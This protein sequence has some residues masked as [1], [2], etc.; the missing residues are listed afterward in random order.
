MSEKTWFDVHWGQRCISSP[1]STQIVRYT[2]PPIQW[3][4]GALKPDIKWLG[5]ETDYLPCL[6][7]GLRLT[8]LMAYTQTTVSLLF[9]FLFYTHMNYFVACCIT[10][11][12]QTTQHEW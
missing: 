6:A 4:M 8:A 2:Q 11:L 9:H 3:I 10:S 12:S 7:C 5:H 1:V